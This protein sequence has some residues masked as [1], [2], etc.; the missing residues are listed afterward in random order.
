MNWAKQIIQLKV[1]VTVNVFKLYFRS[2]NY[3]DL[4]QRNNATP[5]YDELNLGILS[6]FDSFLYTFYIR[7]CL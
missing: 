7:A 6:C 5:T 2:A 4:S 1:T 3:E